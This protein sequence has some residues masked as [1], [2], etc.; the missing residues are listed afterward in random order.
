M[1]ITK[2]TLP[3]KIKTE[4]FVRREQKLPGGFTLI[5]LL[6]VIA[7]IAILAALLLPALAAAKSRAQKI[8]CTSNLKQIT[9]AAFMYQQDFGPIGY[10]PATEWV[11]TLTA[12]MSKVADARFC[13]VAQALRTDETTVGGFGSAANSWT[14]NPANPASTNSG[15][16]TINGWLYEQTAA[17]TMYVP[18]TPSG[19]YFLKDSAITQPTKTPEFGDGLTVDCF[20]NNN[21]TRTDPSTPSWC[22]SGTA[23]LWG[24]PAGATVYH[25]RGVANAPIERYLI[26]RHGSF[27]PGSAPKSVATATP[28]PGAINLSFADGHV[29]T[30]KLYTLWSFMWSGKSQVKSQPAN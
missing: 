17:I 21:A 6:V 16:Y 10:D 1:T 24:P 13:P 14:K 30:V 7:I 2:S 15:S 8:K 19:S 29:E 27:A 28:F 25:S 5:E 9:M 4:S 11:E 26:A 18:D 23:N 20:P 12:N 22:S 3:M